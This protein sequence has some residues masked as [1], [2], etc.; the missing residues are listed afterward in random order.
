VTPLEALV[1]LIDSIDARAARSDGGPYLK[2]AWID[3]A[4]TD[5]RQ[6][7]AEERCESAAR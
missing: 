1:L 6:V 2:L 4:L 7:L 3:D 5:A